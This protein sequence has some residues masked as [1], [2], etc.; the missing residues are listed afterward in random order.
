LSISVGKTHMIHSGSFHSQIEAGNSFA[1]QKG[2]R[3]FTPEASP[4]DRDDFF[5]V[6]T[7]NKTCEILDNLKTREPFAMFVGFHAPHEPYVM[8]EE[9]FDYCK[10]EDV[11]LPETAKEPPLLEKKSQAYKDRRELFEKQLGHPV[12]DEDIKTGIAG[13]YCALKMVDDCLGKIISKLEETSLLENTL[14][15][16]TSDHGDVLGEH[17]IFNKGATYYDSETRIPMM[18]RFPE[19]QNKGKSISQLAASV[20][21]TPTLFDLLGIEL[22]R[23]FPGYSLKPLIENGTSV[24]ESVTCSNTNAMMYRNGEY[25]IWLNPDGDGEMYHLVND[26]LESNNLFNENDYGDKKAHLLQEMLKT[27]MIDDIR[28]H[29]LTEKEERLRLEVAITNEPE[30]PLVKRKKKEF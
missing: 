11:E 15:I 20:D 22:D 1:G 17:R 18:I 26:P 21:F 30:V 27:R 5:D 19:K 12:A 10:A 4:A 13:Y 23:S 28:T 24:R 7:A 8:P 6:A 9:Y 3:H 25:K 14:I 16:Y 2:W 29:K